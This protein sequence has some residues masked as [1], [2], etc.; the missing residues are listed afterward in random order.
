MRTVLIIALAAA[1]LLS[2]P[3][4]PGRKNRAFGRNSFSYRVYN[5]ADTG[6]QQL[7]RAEF[8]FMVVNDLLT[9][10]KTSQGQYRAGYEINVIIYNKKNE[11]LQE[12]FITDRVEVDSFEQTNS[13][14]RPRHHFLSISLPPGDYKYRLQL[15]DTESKSS[16]TRERDIRLASFVRDD[17][18]LSSVV[19]TDRFISP[20][21]Y[22]PNL[23]N[24]FSNSRSDFSAYYEITPPLDSDSVLVFT[25]IFDDNGSQVYFEEDSNPVRDNV[26]P[27][28]V[29]L[30]ENLKKPGNYTLVVH[31]QAGQYFAQRRSKFSVNWGQLGLR[32]ENIDVA[33]EQ[34]KLVA[35]NRDVDRIAEAGPE[36]RK[37]LFDAFWDERDPTPDTPANELRSEFFNRIDFANRNFF[38]TATGREGWRTDR[39]KVYVKYG[40]PDE[41]E[42]PQMEISG[43][44][45]EIWYY[46]RLNQRYIF[47]D[48]SGSGEYRLVKVE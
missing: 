10:F 34:L 47:S 33:L 41:I 9:F 31:A 20:D 36:E 37:T 23:A 16:L 7:S 30:S 26:I 25:K 3:D 32:E 19:F 27:V 12:K 43:P 46:A 39:G 14:S 17:L 1:P 38:E 24:T 44:S 15:Y 45:V 48:R 8:H 11:A 18:H 21:N 13:R 28:Q 22:I 29:S 40:P 42:R 2:Q 5:F 35:H 4:M 6:D